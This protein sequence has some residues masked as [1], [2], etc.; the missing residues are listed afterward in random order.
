MI[1]FIIG[2][3]LAALVADALYARAH[4]KLRARAAHAVTQ[5]PRHHL[6]G[7][8]CSGSDFEQ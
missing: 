4:I 7:S 6:T 5:R 1:G 3:V 8:P 2:A